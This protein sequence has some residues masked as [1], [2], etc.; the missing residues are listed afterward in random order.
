MRKTSTLKKKLLIIFIPLI[1]LSGFVLAISS[2][3]ISKAELEKALNEAMEARSGEIVESIEKQFLGHQRIVESLSSFMTVMSPTISEKDMQEVLETIIW[4]NEETLGAGVWY[5]PFKYDSEKRYVGPYVY[6]DGEHAVFT[7]AYE[8]P[9]YDYPSTDWYQLGVSEIDDTAWTEPYYDD[10]SGM[11]MLTATMPFYENNEIAGVVTA[12]IDLTTLQALIGSAN[13]NGNG[14]TFLIGSDGQYI[15]HPDH[16]KV[17]NASITD[18]NEFE[19]NILETFSLGKVQSGLYNNEPH[20]LFIEEF[21][22]TGWS[23]VLAVPNQVLHAPLQNLMIQMVVY[24]FVIAGIAV[25]IIYF[26]S[27]RLTRNLKA[28]T[29][30]IKRVSEGDLTADISITSNDEIG[31][32][33][34]QFNKMVEDM[35]LLITAMGRTMYQLRESSEQLSSTSEQTMASSQEINRA[36]RDVAETSSVV[37]EKTEETNLS[38]I[39]LAQSIETFT[40][41]VESMNQM[42]EVQDGGYKQGLEQMEI[43]EQVSL[44]SSRQAEVTETRVNQLSEYI[45][46]IESVIAAIQG[47]S[48]QTNL[49]ALNASIEAARA[50]EEGKG[51]AVVASE[52]RKLAEQT[53][54]LTNQ[55]YEK[56]GYV[57]QESASTVTSMNDM[58]D[59]CEEQ[60]TI[61]SKTKELFDKLSNVTQEMSHSMVLISSDIKSMNEKKDSI[62]LRLNQITDGMQQSAAASE[63]I[64]ASADEQLQ[65][66][67]S[68]AEAAEILLKMSEEANKQIKSFKI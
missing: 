7:D 47:I 46:N 25:L 41:Q 53:S 49:L 45:Q 61:V 50:G 58:K 31:L 18:P 20:Q 37:S 15:A 4:S 35:N 40:T 33:G 43:L 9:A 34:K 11:T 62:M 30:K 14:Y 44:K 28:L 32:L 66:M 8:D 10:E 3:L 26:F 38:T 29:E 60:L 22:T 68:V 2:F 48:E 57:K 59:S 65:A 19:G 55:I 54:A 67:N 12:D 1:L 27:N 21:G 42:S 5:E 13:L 24:T 6:K 51:F 52:V 17:M 64:S 39:E 23:L 56:I 36:I 63:E 16:E